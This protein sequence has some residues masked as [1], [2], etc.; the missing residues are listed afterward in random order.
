VN[1]S[2]PGRVQWSMRNRQDPPGG[3]AAPAEGAR[4]EASEPRHR[5][6]GAPRG[7]TRSTD[8]LADVALD[9]G[10]AA[11]PKADLHLH[12]EAWPRLARAVSRRT[13]EADLDWRSNA[14]RVMAEC[15]PGF[16]RLRAILAPA[17][18]L[19]AELA[20]EATRQNFATMIE[21][22]LAEGAADGAVLV[23]VRF[24]PGGCSPFSPGF[25]ELFREAERRVRGRYPRLRAEAI[26]WIDL[27][28]DPAL[29][30]AAER[31][32]AIC[33]EAARAGLGGVDL[34]VYPY[35]AEA[36]PSLW[37]AAYRLG[38]RAAAA[39]LGVTVHAGEFSTANCAAAL[40]M[41]GLRRIGHGVQ[42]AHDRRLLDGLARGGVT[43]ECCPTSNV[44]LGAIPSYEAHP[45]RRLVE[46]GIPV[47][48]STDL[49]VVA[50]TSIGREYAV[51]AALGFSAAELLGFTRNAVAAS[52]GSEERR[53]E[54]LR[55]LAQ[56]DAAGSAG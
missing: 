27:R 10:V 9:P 50:C 44:V 54:L 2:A 43:V 24:G 8:A 51:A 28:D 13:G 39:G 25:M 49:P 34:M 23:E 52:F 47:A 16:G 40:R 55:E 15:P 31:R 56:G 30:E 46:H 33:L 53:A 45:L 21:E 1:G 32:L 17:S 4:G 3:S 35:D 29:L 38:E 22:I 6:G 48:L 7:R 42:Y 26:A 12:Q 20:A 11:V 5:A 14:R 41:P 37:S 19:A 36:D 18:T